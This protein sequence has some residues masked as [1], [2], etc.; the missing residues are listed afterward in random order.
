MDRF[1]WFSEHVNSQI[2]FYL[3]TKCFPRE[4]SVT[5]FSDQSMSCFQHKDTL[6]F[7]SLETLLP[8]ENQARAIRKLLPLGISPSKLG[9]PNL[10]LKSCEEHLM[11]RNYLI[12]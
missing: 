10:K 12:S 11:C 8:K 9:L 4:L 5:F 6:P 3:E 1:S 2:L 7:S